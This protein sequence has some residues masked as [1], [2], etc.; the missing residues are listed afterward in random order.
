MTP[1]PLTRRLVALAVRPEFWMACLLGWLLVSA[2]RSLG[3][4][5]AR[6]A[7]TEAVRWGAGV[8]LALTLGLALRRPDLG[9]R[10]ATVLAGLMGLAGV[11]GGFLPGHG[12]LAGPYHDHQLYGSAL[13]ILLPLPV[14][15]ALSSRV[16]AWRWGGLAVAGGGAV[17][18]ILSETRS[19]WAGGLAALLVFAGLWLFRAGRFE[20]VRRDGRRVLLPILL[21]LGM[22]GA[23]WLMADTGLRGPVT[24]R[25]GTLTLLAADESWQT[26][27]TDWRGAARLV[28]ARPLDGIGLGRYPSRQSAWADGGLTLEPDARPSLSEEAHS[29]YLQTAAETGLVGLGLYAGV[30]LTFTL[31]AL[32]ELRRSRGRRL[33]GRTALLIAALSLVA[34]QAVD[35]LA[36]P[37]WQ[38]GE[39]SLLFWGLLGL[40]LAALRRSETEG[41]TAYAPPHRLGRYAASGLAAVALAANLLPVGLLT[42]VEAYN[43]SSTVAFDHGV[44]TRITNGCP[45]GFLCF[46]LTAYY[47]D[48]QSHDVTFDNGTK[49]DGSKGT[50]SHFNCGT[51]PPSYMGL[52]S[53]VGFGSGVTRNQGVITQPSGTPIRIFGTFQDNSYTGNILFAPQKISHMDMTMP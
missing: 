48:G 25:A 15:L 38:F 37:S 21:L 19:A 28:A 4:P 29:F 36:S 20:A 42:P 32:R 45:A 22:A 18:L 50:P 41:S 14:A 24:Q 33:Q 6:A 40:G 52:C 31:Q 34:G 39:T 51:I 13:L 30:L 49:L 16:P 23:F 43:H 44:V 12:G 47:T 7:L 3:T 17:C 27:L 10:L 2:G 46:S 11:W 5:W 26:R 9:A 35:A 53:G 1:R 8:G